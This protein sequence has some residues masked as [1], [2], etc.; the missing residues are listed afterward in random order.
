MAVIEVTDE[1]AA[2]QGC[3]LDVWLDRLAEGGLAALDWWQCPAVESV[4]GN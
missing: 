2:A 4:P 3:T 1:Q